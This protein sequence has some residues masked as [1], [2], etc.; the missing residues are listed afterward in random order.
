MSAPPA[1]PLKNRR[2]L[3]SGPRRA[4]HHSITVGCMSKQEL[5]RAKENV[6]MAVGQD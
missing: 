6:N 5:D 1:V 2:A 3:K 4:T